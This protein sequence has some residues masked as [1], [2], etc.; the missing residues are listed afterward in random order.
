M[1]TLW[2]LEPAHMASLSVA[3]HAYSAQHVLMKEQAAQVPRPLPLVVLIV[4]LVL[5]LFYVPFSL[6]L[7]LLTVRSS[8]PKQ[9]RLRHFSNSDK[10]SAVQTMTSHACVLRH[11]LLE[12]RTRSRRQ[13]PSAPRHPKRRRTC[14]RRCPLSR[15]RSG[16]R[17]H[18]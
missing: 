14:P 7:F 4:F 5:I 8:A 15:T 17:L 13:L 11:A 3:G 9:T 2:I 12:K 18:M 10:M 6:F 1:T 16:C